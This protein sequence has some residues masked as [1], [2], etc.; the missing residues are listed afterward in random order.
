MD[1]Q[2]EPVAIEYSRPF[3]ALA[4]LWL[5]IACFNVILPRKAE[6]SRK[7]SRSS[8]PVGNKRTVADT[9]FYNSP[10]SC[11]PLRQSSSGFHFKR[12]RR[13]IETLIVHL[14]TFSSSTSRHVEG[15]RFFFFFSPLWK[16]E[17]N[18]RASNGSLVNYK[19]PQSARTSSEAAKTT[20]V[21]LSIIYSNVGK[22][23]Y[24]ST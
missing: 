3:H 16:R 12:H 20:I 22:K 13:V 10:H 2:L 4:Q 5:V 9:I 15:T 8:S 18:R 1:L 19:S 23:I 7:R 21:K 24:S 17:E 14:A 6:S 11:S